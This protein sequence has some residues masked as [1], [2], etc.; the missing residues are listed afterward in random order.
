MSVVTYDDSPA[1]AWRAALA[2]DRS[3][4]ACRQ[5]VCNHPDVVYQGLVPPAGGAGQ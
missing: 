2:P 3:C 1:G 5:R 4:A